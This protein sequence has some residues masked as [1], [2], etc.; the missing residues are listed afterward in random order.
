MAR[1]ISGS[2]E[3]SRRAEPTISG[4]MAAAL[5]NSM[6]AWRSAVLVMTLTWLAPSCL[7]AEVTWR[8][9][10]VKVVKRMGEESKVGLRTDR[11]EAL[12]KLKKAE[13]AKEL[14]QDELKTLEV[15]VQKLIDGWS[16]QIDESVA[17]KE[18]EITTV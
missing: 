17:F 3:R 9:E 4:R 12:E 8:K 13:K 14:S 1:V 18:K 6:A 7:M 15:K 10:M 5:A 2:D 11:H 16:K